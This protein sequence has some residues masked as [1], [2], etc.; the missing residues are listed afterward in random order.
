MNCINSPWTFTTIMSWPLKRVTV[1]GDQYSEKSVSFSARLIFSFILFSFLCF[2]NWRDNSSLA[3]VLKLSQTYDVQSS[4]PGKRTC[5]AHSAQCTI[6]NLPSRK[7]L[8]KLVGCVGL[9][10]RQRYREVLFHYNSPLNAL[11]RMDESRA[12]RLPKRSVT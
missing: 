1:R 3:Q 2:S 6:C 7:L 4:N 5:K 8:M 10:H 12:S 9:S 11:S